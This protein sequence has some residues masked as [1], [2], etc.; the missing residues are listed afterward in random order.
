MILN[1]NLAEWESRNL[2][3]FQ[4]AL[5]RDA[6]ITF[7]PYKLGS[8][9]LDFFFLVSFFSQMKN[10]WWVALVTVRF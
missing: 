5:S 1:K 9:Y 7:L 6:P 10:F 8:V 4:L 2:K 3:S